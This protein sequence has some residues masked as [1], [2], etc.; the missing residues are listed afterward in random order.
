MTDSD[1][2][3]ESSP[4]LIAGIAVG[5][6]I[7]AVLAFMV[8]STVVGGEPSLAETCE[9]SKAIIRGL[10][11][12]NPSSDPLS[13]PELGPLEDSTLN[14]A[15]LE[16]RSSCTYVDVAEFEVGEVF[17]WLGVDPF[18]PLPTDTSTPTTID[19]AGQ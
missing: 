1:N 7:A 17:P 16:M 2:T 15:V 14:S 12:S 11:E 5:A 3:R 19:S 4:L 10:M 8:T 9:S 18:A 13:P 6:L